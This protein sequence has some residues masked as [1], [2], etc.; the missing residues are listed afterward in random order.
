MGGQTTGTYR[1][2][3]GFYGLGYMPNELQ[4]VIDF[5]LKNV[6]FINCYI[7]DFLIAS[8]GSLEEYQDILL[9]VLN[10]LENKN[11]AVNWEKSAFFPNRYRMIGLQNFEYRSETIGWKS[12]PNTKPHGTEKHFT[13]KVV[14]R[15]NKLYLKFVLNLSTLCTPLRPLLNKESI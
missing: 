8:K 15:I 10:I 3:T 2:L 5:L 13:T 7:E 1:F 6:P 9:K 4:R 11:M 12:G 14:L